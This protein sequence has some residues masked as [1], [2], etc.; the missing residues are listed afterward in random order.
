[1]YCLVASSATNILMPIG[2]SDWAGYNWA[3][4]SGSLDSH[5]HLHAKRVIRRG[6]TGAGFTGRDE[7]QATLEWWK[8]LLDKKE[9][10][11]PDRESQRNARRYQCMGLWIL[12]NTCLRTD[13]LMFLTSRSEG[14]RGHS[15]EIIFK[16]WFQK[17]DRKGK[18][19]FR[20]SIASVPSSPS[21]PF[22][23]WH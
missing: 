13:D 23:F 4:L 2:L 21:G 6:S 7:I 8:Q 16:A 12:E 10:T 14:K 15:T 17:K 18:L 11:Y 1:M 3:L 22:N 19:L 5:W 20:E 9:P